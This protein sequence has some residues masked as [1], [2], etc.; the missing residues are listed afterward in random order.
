LTNEQLGD[1]KNRLNAYRHANGLKLKQIEELQTRY[2]EMIKDAEEA[3]QTD[4]GESETAAVSA[5]I[6]LLTSKQQ[7]ERLKNELAT[8]PST[9]TNFVA[10][11][12]YRICFLVENIRLSF[13]NR[14]KDNINI[15]F[16]HLLPVNV[17][18]WTRQIDISLSNDA[19]VLLSSNVVL[20]THFNRELSCLDSNRH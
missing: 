11:C 2:N 12:S 10:C 6:L 17:T 14:S 3:V 5:H 13:V 1:L 19:I 8:Q 16:R 7:Y 18:Q 15:H 4:A 9:N 20:S